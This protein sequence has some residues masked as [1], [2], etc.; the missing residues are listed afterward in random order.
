VTDI[1]AIQER[2][3]V[4]QP[5]YDGLAKAVAEIIGSKLRAVGIE[6]RLENRAKDMA[7]LLLKALEK[8][9][10]YESI[11]DKAGVR[12][13]LK[14]AQDRASAASAIREVLHAVKEEDFENP[15]DPSV[16]TYSGIHFDI[17]HPWAGQTLRCEVQLHTPGESFWANAV[18]DLVYKGSGVP[19]LSQRVA[20]R[21][22]AVAELFDSESVRLRRTLE[23]THMQRERDTLGLLRRLYMPFVASAGRVNLSLDIIASLIPRLQMTPGPGFHQALAEFVQGN[24]AKLERIYARREA[25]PLLAQPESLLMFYMLEQDPTSLVEAWPHHLPENHP[26]NFAELWGVPVHDFS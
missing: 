6:C 1:K 22:R 17:E 7:S 12:A 14:Y 8:K 9:K 18:H 13:V 23:E 16:F 26:R 15:E 21:L 11:G 5:N 25:D 3:R 20:H 4:E 2:Y 10:A 19:Y 24:K